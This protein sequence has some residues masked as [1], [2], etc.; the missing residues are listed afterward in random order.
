MRTDG[1]TKTQTEV[2][3]YLSALIFPGKHNPFEFCL[4]RIRSHSED[5]Q[6]FLPLSILRDLR[7]TVLNFQE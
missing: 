4:T 6:P 5:L 3:K 2:D 1:S 7:K